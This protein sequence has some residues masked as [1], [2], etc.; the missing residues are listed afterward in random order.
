MNNPSKTTLSLSTEALIH[1]VLASPV[2][3]GALCRPHLSPSGD[4]PPAAQSH[5][6]YDVD[7][8]GRGVVC[9]RSIRSSKRRHTPHT[10]ITPYSP[11]S[12]YV[13]AIAPSIEHLNA[14]L[15]HLLSPP[16]VD[17]KIGY[18]ALFY[19]LIMPYSFDMD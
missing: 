1:T 19:V 9:G 7:E 5:G 14:I 18:H 17:M 8:R 2:R 6:V 13:Y 16:H 15:A 12:S 4:I 3:S 10:H 11:S